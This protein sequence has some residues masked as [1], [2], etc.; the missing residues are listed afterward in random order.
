MIVGIN[1]NNLSGFKNIHLFLAGLLAATL[2]LNAQAVDCGGV[3]DWSYNVS[4][5]LSVQVKQDGKAFMAQSPSRGVSP[6]ENV[7]SGR[8]WSLVGTCS[9]EPISESDCGSEWYSSALT[10][11][12]S[13]PKLGSKECTTFNGCTWIGEFFGLPD[14]KLEFWVKANNIVAVHKKDWGWL[15]MKTLNL[16]QGNKHIT[17]KVYDQCDDADCDG[18]CSQN[19][20][21]DGF[22]IDIEKY[23]M[24]RFGSGSGIVEFQV[25]N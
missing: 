23:T 6:K 24:Q 16:R 17:A 2:S 21:G 9:P 13:Y 11:Y 5:R 15:G 8:A 3:Q 22:L 4:Y 1:R 7:G 14:K 12:E 19:L 20:G 10:N 25:C 18:C